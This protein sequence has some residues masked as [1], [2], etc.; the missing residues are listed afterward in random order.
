MIRARIFG[1]S[2]LKRSVALRSVYR[3]GV[4]P[5]LDVVSLLFEEAKIAAKLSPQPI[6]VK[7]GR[8]MVIRGS[9]GQ[10]GG[11]LGEAGARKVL[12]VL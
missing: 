1:A 8:L 4:V 9:H 10:L 2:K 3:D 5:W 11:Y 12:G 6:D 7:I